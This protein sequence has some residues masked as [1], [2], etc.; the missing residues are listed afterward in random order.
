MEKPR[1]VVDR[2]LGDGGGQRLVRLAL[3]LA[4]LEHRRHQHVAGLGHAGGQLAVGV[5]RLL[6]LGDQLAASLSAPGPAPP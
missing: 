5:E 1:L 2:A 4:Q 3:R 6:G